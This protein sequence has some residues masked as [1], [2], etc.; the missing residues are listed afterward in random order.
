MKARILLGLFG[1]A[2][3]SQALANPANSFR[4]VTTHEGTF[5]VPAMFELDG[6]YPNPPQPTSVLWQY[7]NPFFMVPESV[8]LSPTVSTLWVGNW[9]NNVRLQK[10]ALPGDGT[11]IDVK[12]SPGSGHASRAAKDADLCVWLE[13]TAFTGPYT[14][15][16]FRSTSNTEIWSYPFDPSFNNGFYAKDAMRVSRDGAKV[17][18]GLNAYDQNTQ[19]NLGRLFVLD[20]NTGALLQT[21]DTNLFIGGLD[22]S[23]DGSLA[24][25][26]ASAQG[27]LVDTATGAV[28]FNQTVSGAGGRPAMSGNGDVLALGGF[29]LRAWKKVGG[30]Y[31]NFLNFTAPTSWFG[32]GLGVSRDGSTIGAMSHDYNANYLNTVTR[33]WDVATGT[34]LGSYFTFGGG[35]SQDSIVAGIFTDDGSRFTVAS[36][37]TD[38]NAHPEVMIF[39]RNVN[40][41]SWVDTPGSPFGLDMTGNGQYVAVGSKAVH[42]N[43]FG[44]GGHV[45]LWVGE[46]PCNADFNGD[47]QVDF[48]DYL[49]FVSAFADEDP[50]A[51]YNGDG[52]IDFFDYLDFIAD[53]AAGCD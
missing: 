5:L 13:G 19:I 15:S 43:T 12:F 40:L 36:W 42:A 10:F 41:M 17:V 39:D 21:W 30:V 24:W 49:D 9:L 48:F 23:D 33:T 51:D 31:Q 50:S 27:F 1:A 8:S 52:Q 26:Q 38:D 29:N 37:G 2:I 3:A 4:A 16:A 6:P 25:V 18:I 32:W 28:L 44:N 20:G 34:M 35:A 53:F 14:L 45:T 11:P 7:A 22:L 46:R 47:G